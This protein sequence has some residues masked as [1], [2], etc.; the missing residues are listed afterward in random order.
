MKHVYTTGFFAALIPSRI[1][2]DFAFVFIFLLGFSWSARAQHREC[3]AD[4]IHAQKIATDAQYAESHR[5]LEVYT[6]Q[7][8][9]EYLQRQNSA[10]KTGVITI[11]VVFHIINNGEPVGIGTNIADAQ[12]LSQLQVLNEDMRRLNPDAVNTPVRFQSVAADC[13]VEFC[14]ALQ[15][16]QG[17][18]ALAINRVNGGQPDWNFQQIENL[19]PTLAWDPNRYLNIYVADITPIGAIGFA[20]FPVSP[21]PLND[22]IVCDFRTV[23]RFPANP[24]TNF[25]N[26]RFNL[27]RTATH[28]IGHWLNCFH[29]WGDDGN[30]CT[31]SD[32]VNDTPN[33]DGPNFNCPQGTFFSCNNLPNGDMFMNYLDLSDDNCMNLY[34]QGQK[35]RMNATFD[36]IR[37]GFLNSTLCN[38]M[39][40]ATNITAF[41]A[42]LTWSP[43]VG[44]VAYNVRWRII[45]G[46]GI[47][48]NGFTN[49]PTL[50][51]AGLT[52]S[53][54]PQ[55]YQFTAYEWQVQP[56]FA[57][58]TVGA[59]SASQLFRTL[60]VAPAIVCPYDPNENAVFGPY[61]T[62]GGQA[63][64]IICPATDIDRFVI[65][66]NYMQGGLLRLILS[67]LATD[68]D[69]ELRNAANN[70]LLASSTN[71]GT[72]N[73]TI[74]YSNFPMG[75]YY[76]FVFAKMPGIL[77]VQPYTVSMMLLPPGASFPPGARTAG[78]ATTA[79]SL[80]PNPAKDVVSIAITGTEGTF[81]ATLIDMT[82]K[83]LK[84]FSGEAASGEN[85]SFSISDIQSGMYF[86]KV[87]IGTEILTRKLMIAR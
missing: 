60:G 54:N 25:S 28:E 81:I 41:T 48:I 62:P 19:K 11:P 72:T 14:I 30:L 50:N 3:H 80:Y 65:M 5:V 56:I 15:D 6:A 61:L 18:P 47:W 39:F 70:N 20:T 35:A 79:A 86:L 42:T 27:G 69:F 71:T 26:G 57:D 33:Q 17:V 44:A 43:W 78:E 59:F 37:T 76:V 34:T 52:P 12:I 46:N 45:G 67:N 40:T 66:N 51:I 32:Q 8:V 4:D 85:T 63:L 9:D 24:F 7:F 82:G 74:L 87:K 49:V 64:G 10:N 16:P 73:D 68:Y 13:E 77:I 22:G 84:E 38:R 83:R 75:N 29:I 36:F 58:G 1:K 55:A 2:A 21:I 31:G 23:G 53:P